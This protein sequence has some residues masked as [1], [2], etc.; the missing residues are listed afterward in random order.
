MILESVITCPRCGHCAT[1]TMPIDAC[2]FFYNCKCCGEQL[3]PRSGDCCVFCSYGS[4]PCP[5]VQETRA[6][7]NEDC[8]GS[9]Q[10]RSRKDWLGNARA[11]LLAWWLP[12]AAIIA[13]PVVTVPVRTAV[14]VGALVWMGAACLFN[15]RRSGR[16]H[17]WITGPY[18][19]AMVGPVLTLGTGTVAAGLYAWIACALLILVGDKIIW[20]ATERAWGIYS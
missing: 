2:L 15:A 4:M 5:P 1:E 13:G 11:S 9:P 20:W 10:A 6:R 16:T 8:C 14:W 17:C 12:Q 7:D 19:I 18:Y 3:K